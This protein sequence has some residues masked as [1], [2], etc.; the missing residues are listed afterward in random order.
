M[1]NRVNRRV[2][3]INP[4]ALIT[5]RVVI[6]PFSILFCANFVYNICVDYKSSACTSLYDSDFV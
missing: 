3:A 1:L 5:L 6:P 4:A 2:N